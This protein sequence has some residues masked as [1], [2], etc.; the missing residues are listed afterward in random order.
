MRGGFDVIVCLQYLRERVEYLNH[1]LNYRVDAKI[2]AL[3]AQSAQIS[4]LHTEVSHLQ[5]QRNQATPISKLPDEILATIFF[6]FASAAHELSN[7][8]WTRILFVCH[9]WYNVGRYENRLWSYIKMNAH[10]DLD[11]LHKQIP[12]SCG[13]PLMLDLTVEDDASCI[14]QLVQLIE[15]HVGR[16]RHLRV[17]GHAKGVSSFLVILSAWQFPAL[18]SIDIVAEP[19]EPHS[20]DTI[21]LPD[22]MLDGRASSLR[23]VKLFKSSVSLDLLHN[24]SICQ[25]WTESMSFTRL[26]STF[27]KSPGLRKLKLTGCMN[28]NYDPLTQVELLE[29]E[30]LDIVDRIENCVDVLSSII[31][32]PTASMKIVC[33]ITSPRSNVR[34]LL[35]P[36]RRHF[37]SKSAYPLHTLILE[38]IDY[39]AIAAFA[40]TDPTRDNYKKPYLY[41]RADGHPNTEPQRRRI[42]RKVLNS[43]PLDS[44]THIDARSPSRVSET[45]W[46]MIF[47]SLPSMDTLMLGVNIWSLTIARALLQMTESPKHTF[48]RVKCIQLHTTSF[49]FEEQPDF[50]EVLPRLSTLL[51]QLL[52]RYHELGA[53]LREFSVDE[54]DEQTD[55]LD[56]L[57]LN[58][59]CAVVGKVTQGGR[60]YDPVKIV[61]TNLRIAD[62]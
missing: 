6:E 5:I 56:G 25:L 22:A 16:F 41:C 28:L 47:S 45:S 26:V 54:G 51:I 36:I 42:I 18:E 62:Y 10:D 8:A 9:R 61:A 44:I 37:R 4:S 39:L 30:S 29:L 48:F 13:W 1:A 20:A 35:V 12:R 43:L 17:C 27:I 31:I 11:I 59:L 34:D 24:L 7:L 46:K 2:K 40:H 14:V 58:S 53:S 15:E 55:G 49:L 50:T 57:T 32:P 23:C 52:T 21:H 3:T 19:I 60:V 33:L 38:G